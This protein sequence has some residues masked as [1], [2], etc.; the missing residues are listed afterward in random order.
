[1]PFEQLVRRTNAGEPVFVDQLLQATPIQYRESVNILAERFPIRNLTYLLAVTDFYKGMNYSF[2]TINRTLPTIS[3]SG[4]EN[5]FDR[6]ASNFYR[7]EALL[8]QKRLTHRAEPS[9]IALQSSLEEFYSMC[10]IAPTSRR[11]HGSEVSVGLFKT[12]SHHRYQ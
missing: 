6:D 12:A 2:P 8:N 11:R 1:M 7:S 3:R 10:N 5:I 4:V 9:L